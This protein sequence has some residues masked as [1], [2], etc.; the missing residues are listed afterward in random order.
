MGKFSCIYSAVLVKRPLWAERIAAKHDQHEST[1][2]QNG[3]EGAQAQNIENGSA[4]SAL[5]GII[6]VAVK[7]D[8]V[9]HVPDLAFGRFDQPQLNIARGVFDS[10]IV[11]RNATLRREQ[12]NAAGMR[13][14]L[15]LRVPCVTEADS[16][17]QRI[18]LVFFA[19]QEMPA[20]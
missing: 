16:L 4:I 19:G 15:D 5:P 1:Q 12:H 14:L 13:V 10:V 6:V 2:R 9:H 8:L 17:R 18:D 20:F 11:L 7:K 3:G